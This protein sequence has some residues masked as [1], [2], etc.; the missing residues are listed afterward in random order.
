M[1]R[2]V[3]IL[4]ACWIGLS[5]PGISTA[6]EATGA[7][8]GRILYDG[9]PP[10]LPALDVP[11]TRTTLRDEVY[12]SAEFK[13]YSGLGLK[14]ESLVISK[15]GG[16]KNAVIW[17]S[18]KKVPIPPVPPNT[19]LPAPATLTF[20]KGKL[21]PQVLAWWAPAR[22]LELANKDPIPIN[23]RSDAYRSQPFNRLLPAAKSVMFSLDAEPRPIFV[24]C[25]ILHW[26]PPAILFPCAH[27]FV[28]VTDAEGRFTLKNLPLGTWEFTTWHRRSGWLR[29]TDWPKG[30]FTQ[31]IKAGEQVLGEIKVPKEL[32]ETK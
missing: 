1:F 9:E 20:A 5:A 4:G 31:E 2:L 10:E 21:E 23:L 14:D 26:L 25:D 32:F 22:P 3:L 16:L 18:D 30:R 11:T 6:E 8:T 28:A 13:R 24:R 15:T 7:L 12:E 19:R 17:I 29:T 27:P